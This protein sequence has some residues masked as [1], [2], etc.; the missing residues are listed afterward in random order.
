MSMLRDA[1]NRRVLLAAAALLALALLVV[2]DAAPPAQA[3]SHV[4]VSN[5][6][7]TTAHVNFAKST[8]SSVV[9]Q[10]FTTGSESGGYALGSIEAKILNAPTSAQRDTV[11]AE[12]WSSSSGV[13]DAKL[14]DLTVPA[15]PISAGTVTFTDPAKTSL[16]AST[17]YFF[18]IYTTGNFNVDVATTGTADQDS[19]SATG[20]TIND[21]N[22]FPSSG[23]DTNVPTGVSG[24]KTPGGAGYPVQL[25]VNAPEADPLKL[26]ALR[27]EGSPDGGSF[28]ALTLDP[29]FDA[30]TG[31]YWVTVRNHV[32]H[33]RLTPTLAD[34][35]STLQVGKFGSR[36]AVDSG[37]ASAAVALDVGEN[38]ISVE[39]TDTNHN[40]DL[41]HVYVQRAPANQLVGN[42]GQPTY[43]GYDTEGFV[44]AQGF[45][46]GANTGGY[47]LASIDAYLLADPS[48][49]DSGKFRAELWSAA[50]GGGPDSRVASLTVP[51]DMGV[52]AVSFAAPANTTLSAS[53]KYYAVFYTTDDTAIELDDTD[54]TGE[55]AGAGPR[56]NLEDTGYNQE[57]EQPDSTETWGAS[58][59]SD[60]L[61]KIR[62]RGAAVLGATDLSAL[63][64]VRTTDQSTY[65]DTPLNPDF[66]GETTAYRVAV[67]N[68]VTHV[69]LT[70]TLADTNSSVKVG[71]AGSLASVGN[72]SNSAD[73]A[74]NAGQNDIIVEVTDTNSNTQNYTVT[75]FRTAADV[76]ATNVGQEKD[77]RGR[78][79]T[80]PRSQPFTTGSDPA[81]YTLR[82]IDATVEVT[83]TVSATDAAK[84]TAEVW[85]N[86]ASGED[87][88]EPDAKL[89]DLTEPTSISAGVLTF[90]A[91]ANTSLAA[92]T[93]YH[94]VLK[95]SGALDTGVSIAW[96]ATDSESEDIAQ[97]GWSVG[98]QLYGSF[99][100]GSDIFWSPTDGPLHISVNGASKTPVVRF[101]LS[102]KTVTETDTI[103]TG[104]AAA[105]MN[106]SPA[107]AADLS[108]G[109]TV[110]T[111]GAVHQSAER[112]CQAG[113]DFIWT[114]A[115]QDV[116]AGFTRSSL[117]PDICG[118]TVPE[119]T[120]SFTLTLQPGTGYILGS[121]SSYTVTITDDDTPVAPT[122][123]TLTA[124]D[125]KLDVSWT[126]PPGA[127]TSYDVHYTGARSM[128]NGAVA[129]DAALQGNNPL[130][131]WVD[132][133]HTGT[134]ASDEIT[135]LDN[136]QPY[137]VR[138]RGR[139]SAGPGAWAV[140]TETPAPT[141]T[142]LP[143]PVGLLKVQLAG[144]ARLTLDWNQPSVGSGTITGYDVHYT[145]NASVADD[146]AA[147]TGGA[148]AGWVDRGH[149][150]T[151]DMSVLVNL[152]NDVEH[153]ARVRAKNAQGHGPWRFASG[154]PT[155]L[156][157]VSL[158]VM[159]NP[160]PEGDSVAVT[161]TLNRQL[162]SAVTVP[163]TITDRTA[164]ADD[165]GT[166]ASITIAANTSSASATLT[167]VHDGDEDD[168]TF[169]VALGSSLPAAV[170]AHVGK[171]SVT[172]TISDQDG[173]GPTGGGPAGRVACPEEG[174]VWSAN[175]IAGRYTHQSG[176]V[177]TGY[178][179]SGD[180]P[181]SLSI[182]GFMYGETFHKLNQVKFDTNSSDASRNNRLFLTL[183]HGWTGDMLA[184]LSLHVD[185]L[186][187]HLSESTVG[188][189]DPRARIWNAALNWRQGR[190]YQ[191]CL[192]EAL[193]SLAL[194]RYTAPE[195]EDVV[196][197][198]TLTRP[199]A[200]DVEI[201]LLIQ[202]VSAETGDHGSAPTITIPAGQT[203]GTGVIRTNHDDDGDHERFRVKIDRDSLPPSVREGKPNS[204][205]V[206]IRDD[207]WE[208]PMTVSLSATPGTVQEG[209]DVTV[210]ATLHIRGQRAP[211]P[212]SYVD[213]MTIPLRVV[214]E[215]S[216]EGDHGTLGS[217]TIP[218]EQSSA[219]ATIWTARD[220]DG[221][222]ETF[223]VSLGNLPQFQIPRAGCTTG[224]RLTISERAVEPGSESAQT[225]GECTYAYD[226]PKTEPF[227]PKQGDDSRSLPLSRLEVCWDDEASGGFAECGLATLAA[228][229][230]RAQA[231]KSATHVKIRPTTTNS[232]AEVRVR[233]VTYQNGVRTGTAW[234]SVSAVPRG[235]LSAAFTLDKTNPNTYAEVR[236]LD[237]G[238]Y[239]TYLLVIDPPVETAEE[240][241][242]TADPQEDETPQ[243]KYADLIA[244]V[245]EWR[246][247]PCCA[248]NKAHTDRWDRT[249]LAFGESVADGTLTP[250][251]AD[252]AQTYADRGWTRW[253]EVTA[254]LRE[255]EAGAQHD[256]PNNAPTVS[257]AIDDA[258][259][260]N[261]SGTL[262]VS[263]TGVF[264]DAD[265][266]SLTITAASSDE[267]AA[268]V[269]VAADGSTLTVTAGSI[270]VPV[271]TV[272]ADDGNGSTVSD[273]FTVRVKAAPVVSSA[274]ADVSGL[275]AG[276]TRDVSLTG[277]FADADGD[278]LTITA[279]SSDEAVATVTVAADESTL[280][281]AGEAE[282]TATITVTAQ[283]SDGN[284]VS[285]TFDV[286]V[287]APQ[288][289]DPPPQ[290]DEETPSGAPTVAAPL[291]DLSLVGPEL[292]AIDL[293]AVF[294]GEGLTFTAVSSNPGVAATWVWGDTLSV[295]GISTGTAT[296]TVTAEDADGNRVSDEFEVT[297]R[298]AN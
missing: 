9:A 56:W 192:S 207:E 84:V 93:T 154:M 269:S 277:V 232:G 121:P 22:H 42:L 14:A 242:D 243:E 101:G 222:D 43:G 208:S 73:I 227:V 160:V 129:D 119:G 40:A 123:L 134:T 190:H 36:V 220:S 132:A 248:S 215:T 77:T 201:P 286:T 180:H 2:G 96:T 146:A 273:A 138:V 4:L 285:D 66:T 189:G 288:Q 272:T 48:A 33:A 39:I 69:K 294:S 212:S 60:G 31:E 120:E 197:K 177:S 26:T 37:S 262:E 6:G 82:S 80:A 41:Y 178:G 32:T 171:S 162:T 50:T 65:A 179:V 71:V 199:A 253:V 150:S 52:D 205:Q 280:T 70:P 61:I 233:K 98:D 229:G 117:S 91:P 217:I 282:G 12:L 271:I 267:V 216:E 27:A 158:T 28:T 47:T 183:R 107:P 64:M 30:D 18:L 246:D 151:V 58:I 13:P 213:G 168:E 172:V 281:V 240:P 141:A 251:T 108:V 112:P 221:D 131:G 55:D 29:A 136:N 111:N 140:E 224:V 155:A 263:L 115:T 24:W 254:A 149:A 21:K 165:H 72:G 15:H 85:S 106:V 164:E 157:A 3:S 126:A 284:T 191:V 226:A 230:Y 130:A 7:Q 209:G 109:V 296:I 261:Q 118:D 245:K 74:V 194:A 187:F 159:P 176:T 153:R 247:D 86:T 166:L 161:L 290:Q 270:G 51:S 214:R 148:A 63:A 169:T 76:L 125:E 23:S 54:R 110:T 100:A 268:T 139:S 195:G 258:V 122:G 152:T 231:D 103:A 173:G 170:Q 295:V 135:G 127:V 287:T 34:T 95:L 124:G 210:T 133:S 203:V 256:A 274:I 67:D 218:T 167:T 113:S 237:R 163:L 255:M 145:S 257:A 202:N 188:Q 62:V 44:Y 236:I 211:V 225:M 249:L 90:T 291:P 198:A 239:T 92:D 45:T 200:T 102:A 19:S 17:L 259:I 234:T 68:A 186:A 298:P 279:A 89:Y 94:L 87:A 289:Q 228:Y 8:A 75:V 20:W 81:G 185:G 265:G 137:R 49:A 182:D 1:L 293:S 35:S 250:M 83:G 16:S 252:E 181:G 184:R 116:S 156:P 97:T 219:S 46:T 244:K 10:G 143:G 128:G 147:Q 175:M 241:G 278:S 99:V 266:D 88:G 57:R 276:G 275:D 11:R 260:V 53:T 142:T 105:A 206:T 264:A 238:R 38:L 114:H 59:A 193:V 5:L 196:V 204:L 223:T 292:R 78:L 144:D 283:D 235:E 104:I 174:R 79:A 297:V 25:G